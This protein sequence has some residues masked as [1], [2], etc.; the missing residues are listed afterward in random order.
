M[1]ENFIKNFGMNYGLKILGGIVLLVVGFFLVKL[2]TKFL[3]SEKFL[4]NTDTTVKRFLVSFISIGLKLVLVLTAVILIGVPAATVI[5]VLGSCGLAIGLAL[6][7]GLGNLAGGLL[8]LVLKPY[9]LGDYINCAGGEGNVADIGIFY[10]TLLTLDNI[11]IEIPNG[12]VTSGTIKNY[13]AEKLRR[14]DLDFA[15]SAASDLDKIRG[16]LASVIDQYDKALSDP[17][18]D[19]LISELTAASVTFRIRVWCLSENYW[20][21]YF[22]LIEAVKRSFVENNVDAPLQK[23]GIKNI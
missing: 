1:F 10:T 18:Y 6:Q 11:K 19:I 8:I 17:A 14:V 13:T 9:K 5:A 15:V 22:A 3:R 20:D 7:G 21:V 4:K 2:L 23:M 16:I 12:A